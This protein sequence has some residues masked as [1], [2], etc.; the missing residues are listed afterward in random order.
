MVLGATSGVVL[1]LAI[2]ARPVRVA[3][4]IRQTVVVEMVEDE[5]SSS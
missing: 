4:A 5:V 3:A 1:V 2:V